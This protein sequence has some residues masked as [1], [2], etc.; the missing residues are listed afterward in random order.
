MKNTK[1]LLFTF[2]IL[3]SVPI[4]L[5]LLNQKT[6]FFGKAFGTKA[7]IIIDAGNIVGGK[8]ENWRYLAQGG[9]ERGR[10]LLPV[11][12]LT[13]AL[14]P[15]YIRI[16]H[17]FDYY[18]VVS[19]DGSGKLNFNWAEF[20][21]YL[22]DIKS[23]GA[24]P[25]ISLSYM[26]PSISKSGDVNDYPTNWEDWETVVKTTIEHV[27]GRSN[28]AISDVYYEVWN[29]P[30]LFGGYKITGEKSYLDLYIHS[31]KGAKEANNVNSFKFGGPAT[32]GF[33]E[34]WMNKLIIFCKENNV[35]LDF[36]SWHRYSLNLDDYEQDFEGASHYSG[37][38]T[39]ISEL[40][41][42]SENND[43]NDNYFGAMHTIATAVTL[44]GKVDKLF[45]FEIKDGPGPTK[46]W[47]RWGI[48]THEKF[49]TPEVKPRYR[50][51]Q[52]LNNL[53]GG[54]NIFVSGN[55]SWI[56]AI[57]KEKNGKV[58]FLIVNYDNQGKNREAVPVKVINLK[59]NEF[60]LKR[61]DFSGKV[62]EQK[63]K[64]ETN[65]YD[66]LLTFEPNTASIFEISY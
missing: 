36:I 45:N 50:A 38:E 7:N 61:I 48:I 28:L 58:I 20:D 29:E 18:N 19:K 52:F 30:D 41:P 63:I 37:L 9:E 22:E 8:S 14:Q 1:K 12:D 32:T 46:N 56:K 65:S 5:I 39:V 66:V 23:I 17:V 13:R 21:L 64:S 54:T 49:G 16:D 2:I 11:I 53:N 4:S 33:Y 27:S 44:E 10:Q 40:G 31:A 60:N 25:F 59:S 15:K 42:D 51:I 3:A 55:G 26:P 47:G 24:K 34:N 6:N 62:S 43:V 57:A 35:R